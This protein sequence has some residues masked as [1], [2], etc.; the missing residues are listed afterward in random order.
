VNREPDHYATLDLPR[1]ATHEQIKRRYRALMREVH[2]DANGADP[3][4]TRKAARLNL[5]FETLS[6]P[7]KRRAY[8]ERTASPLRPRARR[9]RSLND[10]IYAFWAE[11]E[12]WEDIVAET[13][14]PARPAHAHS[15][16]PTIEPEEIEGDYAE[17]QA[18]PRV[19]R[20]IRVTNNC[21]TCTL[22]GDV[23]TSE[24]WVWGPVGRFSA[25]PGE[26]LEFDIEVVA[27]KVRFPGISRALFV[28]NNW[29]GS[30]PVKVTGFPARPRRFF[31]ATDAAYV[32]LR[33]RRWARR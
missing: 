8:D 18:T 26:T 19:R 9:G 25:G 13:V 21:E 14:P 16:P 10:R 31:P 4:A 28:A 33:K 1:S 20:A 27:S 22:T 2:P 30:V 24:P 12:D 29:T 3:H 15:A 32:P 23:S 7:A 11:C 5:A 17:L 6:D